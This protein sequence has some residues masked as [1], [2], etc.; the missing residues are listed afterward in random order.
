[1]TVSSDVYSLSYGIECDQSL[2]TS[3]D[4]YDS[5]CSIDSSGVMLISSSSLNVN[6]NYDYYLKIYIDDTSIFEEVTLVVTFY[7]DGGSTNCPKVDFLGDF[8]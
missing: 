5:I 4:D 7:K 1:M 8:Y 3:Q 6:A 2:F